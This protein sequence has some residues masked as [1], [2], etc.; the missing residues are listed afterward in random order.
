M[1]FAN[2]MLRRYLIGENLC[3]QCTFRLTTFYCVSILNVSAIVKSRGEK[4]KTNQKRCLDNISLR[5]GASV[6]LKF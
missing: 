2:R 4:E 1:F 6:F 5:V 3:K